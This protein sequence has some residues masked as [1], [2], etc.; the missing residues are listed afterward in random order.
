LRVDMRL[1][2]TCAKTRRRL[3]SVLVSAFQNARF[4]GCLSRSRSF[5]Q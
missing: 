4:S 1:V 3:V 5:L 2:S